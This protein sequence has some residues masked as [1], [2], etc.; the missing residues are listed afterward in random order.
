M[1][2]NKEVS[3]KLTHIE[4]TQETLTDITSGVVNVIDLIHK[5]LQSRAA[6]RKILVGLL[7]STLILLI[8]VMGS[9]GYNF[10]A[11]I[12]NRE[13]GQFNAQVLRHL[14]ECLTKDSPCSEE[15]NK[16]TQA[17]V[18]TLSEQLTCQREQDLRTMFPE[19]AS[20]LPIKESCK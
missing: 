4:K 10:R 8:V 11:T 3:A 17:L 7:G 12:K 19:R 2:D 16:T 14:D 20:S 9:A 5:E 15:A 6:S 18:M 13:T 1:P